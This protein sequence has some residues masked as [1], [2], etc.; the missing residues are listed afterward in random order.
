MT[1]KSCEL[2]KFKHCITNI[3]NVQHLYKFLKLY[4][5]SSSV[6]LQS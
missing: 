4:H 1:F 3:N 6:T 2:K 5:M